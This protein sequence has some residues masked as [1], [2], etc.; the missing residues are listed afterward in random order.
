MKRK[1][2]RLNAI[3]HLRRYKKVIM[4]FMLANK[5]DE[6]E[7]IIYELVGRIHIVNIRF[8][9]FANQIRFKIVVLFLFK[10]KV[11]EKEKYSFFQKK[12]AFENNFCTIVV[13]KMK[14]RKSYF[15]K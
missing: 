13:S 8:L 3:K 2:K 7:N 14:E 5:N 10:E 15:G 12:V 4:F 11:Y 1:N 6:K 9:N